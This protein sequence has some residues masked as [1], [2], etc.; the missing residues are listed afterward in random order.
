[1]KVNEID[2]GFLD[3]A[4]IVVY[5]SKND[6]F[7]IQKKKEGFAMELSIQD[8]YKNADL[9]CMNNE[10]LLKKYSDREILLTMTNIM[11]SKDFVSIVISAEKK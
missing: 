4:E 2:K 3:Y 9:V 8:L 5:E 1:M 11:F 6:D 7:F 10:L